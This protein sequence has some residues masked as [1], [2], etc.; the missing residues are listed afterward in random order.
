MEY[1]SMRDPHCLVTKKKRNQKQVMR[2][3][4]IMMSE[5]K[6][7]KVKA[8][9]PVPTLGTRMTV[10]MLHST[11]TKTG[12]IT[13]QSRQQEGDASKE[14]DV[15]KCIVLRENYL[16]R[17]RRIYKIATFGSRASEFVDTVDLYRNVTLQCIENISDW[18][19]SGSASS[20]FLWNGVNYLLRIPSD[21]D[22]LKG[23]RPIE[24][25]IGAPVQRNPFLLERS[26][27]VRRK[28][29]TTKSAPRS[30]SAVGANGK[31]SCLSNSKMTRNPYQQ[32]I[33]NDP[34]M[35]PKKKLGDAP[36]K[37]PASRED[38]QRP[39]TEKGVIELDAEPQVHLDMIRVVGAEKTILQEE[40]L[41]GRYIRNDVGKLVPELIEQE[42]NNT[43]GTK[44]AAFNRVNFM[45][46]VHAEEEERK[47]RKNWSNGM[48]M[49]EKAKLAGDI[50]EIQQLRSHGHQVLP[51]KPSHN[52]RLEIDIRRRSF[53][54]EE[55][56]KGL[57]GMKLA[58]AQKKE[59][60]V[61]REGKADS[62]EIE[63][64]QKLISKLEADIDARSA[65]LNLKRN[66]V[67]RKEKVAK[68]FKQAQ[69][70]AQEK[71]R[72]E[73]I[74]KK[75][76][77]GEQFAELVDLPESEPNLIH[78][79][80]LV[81]N[82]DQVQTL[83]VNLEDFSAIQIQRV[84]R[85]H[86][87]WQRFSQTFQKRTAASLVLQSFWRM[88]KGKI[89]AGRVLREHNARILLQSFMRGVFARKLV[90][91]I[92]K[93]KLQ[94]LGSVKIQKVYRGLKGRIRSKNKKTLSQ[95]AHACNASTDSLTPSDLRDLSMPKAE[96]LEPAVLSL[97]KCCLILTAAGS[98]PTTP[99]M[100]R[101]MTWKACKRALRRTEFLHKLRCLS[102]AIE[103]LACFVDNERLI[104]VQRYLHDP[105][106]AISKLA[107][108]QHGSRAA[109]F[110]LQWVKAFVECQAIIPD[111]VE[112]SA[113]ESPEWAAVLKAD[114][115]DGIQ[116]WESV[117]NEY[118]SDVI[119]PTAYVPEHVLSRRFERPR[120]IIVAFAK[121]IPTGAR[122]RLDRAIKQSVPGLFTH[123]ASKNSENLHTLQT[124]LDGGHSIITDVEVGMGARSRKTFLRRFKLVKTTLKPTPL[125][126]LIK[127]SDTNRGSRCVPFDITGTD[128]AMTNWPSDLLSDESEL[129][130]VKLETSDTKRT[131]SERLKEHLEDKATTEF[132]L[133]SPVSHR[134]LSEL[135]K[136]EEPDESLIL[137]ME[138]VLILLNPNEIFMGPFLKRLK[139]VSWKNATKILE[140]A[141]GAFSRRLKQVNEKEIPLE[142]LVALEE[143]IKHDDFPEMH[144][145][146]IINHSIAKP[147][148][149]WVISISKY[150]RLLEE[151][152]GAPP[153]LSKSRDNIFGAVVVVKDGIAEFPEGYS[154]SQDRWPANRFGD[155]I[156]HSD[157]WKNAHIQLIS[158][159]MRDMKVNTACMQ[160]PI[161]ESP[162]ER[163]DENYS[164]RKKERLLIT[165]H[166][167][168]LSDALFFCAYSPRTC[169]TFVE[170]VAQDEVN[171]LLAP[172]SVEMHDPRQPP[173]TR[174][175]LYERLLELVALERSR[176]HFSK[177]SNA[178]LPPHRLVLRRKRERLLR[179]ARK[180]DGKR[181]II[182]ASEGAPGEITLDVYFTES[183]VTHT[184]VCGENLVNRICKQ[185]ISER[186]RRDLMSMDGQ[187]MVMHLSDRL[188][189]KRA[190][191]EIS[192]STGAATGRK[193]YQGAQLISG[194]K[195]I[196]SVY[197][198]SATNTTRV[199]AYHPLKSSSAGFL[200]S[201]RAR[202]QLLG[203]Q[204]EGDQ[205]E[206]LNELFTR[207]HL[208]RK[209][210]GDNRFSRTMSGTLPI[211]SSSEK[212]TDSKQVVMDKSLMKASF[213]VPIETEA[214]VEND[215]ATNKNTYVTL[216][217]E[218]CLSSQQILIEGESDDSLFGD[219]L[220]DEARHG[221]YRNDTA[222]KEFLEVLG[223]DRSSGTR[224][225]VGLTDE[226]LEK[227][228]GKQQR[229]VGDESF[230]DILGGLKLSNG[231]L[232]L[233]DARLGDAQVKE[234]HGKPRLCENGRD[235]PTE[236]VA[237]PNVLSSDCPTNEKAIDVVLRTIPTVEK[238]D[239]T[240]GELIYQRGHKIAGN[241]FAVVSFFKQ[242][243]IPC[244]QFAD[245][246]ALTVEA[247][248]PETESHSIV[249]IQ[250]VAS[251]KAVL[252]H[253]EDLMDPVRLKDLISFIIQERLVVRSRNPFEIDLHMDRIIHSTK[254][255]P[256]HKFNDEDR[257]ANNFVIAEG[258]GNRGTKMASFGRNL[259]ILH[260]SGK[261]E[262]KRF[263]V[264]FFKIGLS[265]LRVQAYNQK[266]QIQLSLEV[267]LGKVLEAMDDH[268]EVP[269]GAEKQNHFFEEVMSFL[270]V[271]RGTGGDFLVM[272]L[273]EILRNRRLLGTSD[274][275]GLIKLQR[276][277]TFSKNNVS[278]VISAKKDRL[279]NL[280]L[281]IYEPGMG[282]S[283]SLSLRMTK[284]ALPS[285]EI[286]Q[287]MALKQIVNSHLEVFQ[288]KDPKSGCIALRASV[289]GQKYM[290]DEKANGLEIHLVHGSRRFEKS[291]I[292][293]IQEEHKVAEKLNLTSET[294]LG[295][296]LARRVAK[297]DG[298]YAVVT[299]HEIVQQD[300]LTK[301]P[302]LHLRVYCPSISQQSSLTIPWNPALDHERFAESLV[303]Q[304]TIAFDGTNNHMSIR[305]Q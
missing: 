93:A 239:K 53:E 279:E 47:D 304:V 269:Q 18:K 261:T 174:K 237:L 190:T 67:A 195:H 183:S 10:T 185:T 30:R 165:I 106:L 295:R 109:Q 290:A 74:A 188:T 144:S 76:K 136:V 149:W 92:S 6:E 252:R 206:S 232:V 3:E 105:N 192:L 158:V 153:P 84:I 289:Y 228:F 143:Y 140:G 88:Y 4:K 148:L 240:E 116:L 45:D 37:P 163:R 36:T 247:Y 263:F 63:T 246:S 151:E 160:V 110:L 19:R 139:S 297:I 2:A 255:T 302:S 254:V 280:W 61:A 258:D 286:A 175:A 189:Y 298:I 111:F 191:A 233:S 124:I 197:L 215:E 292:Q 285:E 223:F 207:L 120:P 125:L 75:R 122:L 96:E 204:N 100:E 5:R 161:F 293:E 198:S 265:S 234:A 147:I 260:E 159:L 291:A 284:S 301:K 166:Q 224:Y 146:C 26:I 13:F 271:Q 20:Q 270:R 210:Q 85:G 214:R 16:A 83:A 303:D 245:L 203:S 68:K 17:L 70:E 32:P 181:A 170:R 24:K 145:S 15:L 77:E 97:L 62:R 66:V 178:P 50:S 130:G 276:F 9:A 27:D 28:P 71:I 250:D 87:G 43:H 249:S 108:V 244:D 14:V 141:Q 275:S 251:F 126:V 164:E 112:E 114:H 152:G 162:V 180:V 209:V 213:K 129:I 78:E 230:G 238:G 29:S 82:S 235:F 89:L 41:Y 179:Q 35:L 187:K 294:T 193:V 48:Y 282:T 79:F 65:E 81:D 177:E 274:P 98:Q 150:A 273:E 138:A 218:I 264:T 208:H 225:R 44:T 272:P 58:L 119:D 60:L 142:N 12:G 288:V 107:W 113:R 283:T 169:K 33:V 128:Y 196:V 121:D 22:F 157:G 11:S 69:I 257:K 49:R 267:P 296:L 226:D 156:S 248:D 135:R 268:F 227:F 134:K 259:T 102:L 39:D 64:I 186:E 59:L 168:D 305:L 101:M 1:D 277:A 123:V 117:E 221:N 72:E 211:S 171:K 205:E 103:K 133:A 104:A 172:N 73:T 266:T 236:H 173:R 115:E 127:G 241:V 219:E 154:P 137:L 21:L 52:A 25:W 57:K 217:L 42:S 54:N 90:H 199:T 176:R 34:N 212:I 8:Y 80:R 99:F 278:V 201:S 200:L 118:N 184:L 167:D 55:L 31:R 220:G 243:Q 7:G 95:L 300:D 262:T 94:D 253:R 56:E 194:E 132:I 287:K 38:R 40:A 242:D 86:L 182:T 299:V 51:S 46:P 256:I 155:A 231:S 216:M 222:R 23:N 131:V 202:L 91:S 229:S 281:N